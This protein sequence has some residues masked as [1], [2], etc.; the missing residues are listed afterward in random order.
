MG[1]AWASATRNT[2]AWSWSPTAR[3]NPRAAWS[4]CSPA[5]RVSESSATLTPAT[6]RPRA[7]R[8][9]TISSARNAGLQACPQWPCGPPKVMKTGRESC[10]VGRTLYHH[11]QRGED[12]EL[13][14]PV[15]YGR[16]KEEDRE[17]AEGNERSISNR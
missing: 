8:G 17:T 14:K 12:S 1:A 7:S 10:D 16:L 3:M 5:I 11:Q 6:K 2:P 9:S 13:R 15:A 4:A